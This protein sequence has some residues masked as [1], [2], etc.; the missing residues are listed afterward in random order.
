MEILGMDEFEQGLFMAGGEDDIPLRLCGWL[1][2]M[3]NKAYLE[4]AHMQGLPW[5]L[6]AKNFHHSFFSSM[7]LNF[8][9]TSDINQQPID[10]RRLQR[11]FFRV[12]H[13]P[14]SSWRNEPLR[15]PRG[16]HP[17]A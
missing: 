17:R 10:W 16:Q 15:T 7:L 8:P 5:T 9:K 2:W 13:Q 11:W 6:E 12:R 1:L 14:F 4:V 3:V